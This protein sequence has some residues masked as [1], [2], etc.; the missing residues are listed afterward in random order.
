MTATRRS[1]GEV[2]GATRRGSD[3]TKDVME[4]CRRA[5][6]GDMRRRAGVSVTAACARV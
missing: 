5:V 4:D 3:D 1:S 6:A 2:K